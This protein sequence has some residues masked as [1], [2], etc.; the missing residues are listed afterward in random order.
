MAGKIQIAFP[1]LPRIPSIPGIQIAE[2]G[3]TLPDFDEKAVV[4]RLKAGQVHFMFNI[5]I[6]RGKARIWSA[7]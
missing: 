1:E 6:G 2:A 7:I 3:E 5:G 4:K